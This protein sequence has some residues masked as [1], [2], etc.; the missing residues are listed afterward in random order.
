MNL[1]QVSALHYTP[2]VSIGDELV[3]KIDQYKE[4]ETEDGPNIESFRKYTISIIED[5][6]DHSTI[7]RAN[8]SESEDNQEYV[9][10]FENEHIGHLTD[11]QLEPYFLQAKFIV[12]PN[13]K[14]Y[15]YADEIHDSNSYEAEYSKLSSGWG[16]KEV[17]Q[18]SVHGDTVRSHT[19]N[20]EGILEDYKYS[21]SSYANGAG[22]F[23]GTNTL[24]SINGEI[25]SNSIPGYSLYL[26][27]IFSLIGVIGLYIKYKRKCT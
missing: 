18:S 8:R 22:E 10:D 2:A 3:Y 1:S 13:T 4:W 16:I 25:Y 6:D 23:Y 17:Y 20:K 15:D 11:Y 5:F 9:F 26:L 21:Y 27:M 7:I 14:I 12:V 24:Y 19:F